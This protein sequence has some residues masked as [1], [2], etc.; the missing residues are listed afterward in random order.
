MDKLTR[1]TI[2]LPLTLPIL[3]FATFVDFLLAPVSNQLDYD[4][5]E[6]ISEVAFKIAGV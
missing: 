5:A 1:F 4:P 3:A 2:T 6:T